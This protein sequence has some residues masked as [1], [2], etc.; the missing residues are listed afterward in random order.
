MNPQTQQPAYGCRLSMEDFMNLRNFCIELF[1]QEVLPA[2]ERRVGTLG[3]IVNDAKKGMKNVFKSFWRK[4]RDTS[5]HTK[6]VAK[7]KYDR[8]ESQ[9][10]LL[11]DTAFNMRDYDAALSMYRLVKDDYKADKSV[12]HAAHVNLMMAACQLMLEP[13]YRNRELTSQLEVLQQF[14]QTPQEVF[15]DITPYLV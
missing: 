10:L 5:S 4:P 2:L 3:R 8:I 11:G 13:G 15:L 7:Y 14:I 9:I 6:G 12:V 1:H